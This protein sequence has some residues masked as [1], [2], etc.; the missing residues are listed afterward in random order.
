MKKFYTTVAVDKNGR[1]Y[2]LA[3]VH[4]SWEEAKKGNDSVHIVVNAYTCL[5]EDVRG[6]QKKRKKRKKKKK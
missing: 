4:P 6:K 2:D 5:V 3:K 1:V